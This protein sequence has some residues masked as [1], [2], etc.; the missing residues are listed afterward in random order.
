MLKSKA[1]KFFQS[2]NPAQKILGFVNKN[3]KCIFE[4]IRHQ[5]FEFEFEFLLNQLLIFEVKS[6]NHEYLSGCRSRGKVHFVFN[7]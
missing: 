3:K 5:S 2:Q 7:I 4:N 6:S 1:R